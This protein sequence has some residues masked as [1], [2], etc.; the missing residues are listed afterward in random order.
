[1]VIPVLV[2]Y[3]DDNCLPACPATQQSVRG[4]ICGR[5][6]GVVVWSYFLK[7][8]LGVSTLCPTAI[9]T[10]Q[11]SSADSKNTIQHTDSISSGRG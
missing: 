8:L 7:R 4:Q 9:A 10:G 2:G 11:V 6:V 5:D 1:M 3:E